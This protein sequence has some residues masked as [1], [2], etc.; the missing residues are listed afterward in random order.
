MNAAADKIKMIKTS[1]RC[2]VF[3]L[4]GFIPFI[5]IPFALASL[6]LSFSA[7][8][9]ERNL[10]NPA[11]PHRLGGLICASISLLNWSILGTILVYH[12]IYAFPNN[13]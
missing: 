3:G 1:L 9:M 5:G 4:L 8:K 2:L 13:N 10:W 11:R 6:W 7:R 12:A